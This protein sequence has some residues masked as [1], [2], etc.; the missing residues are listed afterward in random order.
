MRYAVKTPHAL[1]HPGVLAALAAA[2]LFGAGTPLA[3]WLLASIGPWTMAGLLYLGSGIGLFLYRLA[4]RA[5]AA[6]LATG[7]LPWLAGAV[8]AGGVIAPVLLMASLSRMPASAASLLLNF[9][10]VFTALLAWFVFHEN[11]DRRVALG[12][13]AIVCGGAVLSWTGQA[14]LEE[15]LPGLGV[16]GACLAWAIDNNL[17]RRVSLTD[18]TWIAAVKDPSRA[19]SIF[20]W[21]CSSVRNCRRLA[22]WAARCCWDSSP[23]A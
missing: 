21:H 20:R 18:A 23:T 3:K 4:R 14:R 15:I 7:E 17:T 9:E 10:G 1:R 22:Q 6:R 2:L 12:M 16:L 11:V 5:P 8:L 19:R 13:L